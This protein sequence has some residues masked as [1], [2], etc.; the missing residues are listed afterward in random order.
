VLKDKLLEAEAEEA[1]YLLLQE[2]QVHRPVV[3]GGSLLLYILL[4]LL[5]WRQRLYKKEPNLK[6]KGLGENVKGRWT[7]LISTSGLD[8]SM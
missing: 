2:E 1:Y 8:V 7:K 6:L 5:I 3:L 4:Q